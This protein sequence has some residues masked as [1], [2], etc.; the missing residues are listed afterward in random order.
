[1]LNVKYMWPHMYVCMYVCIYVYNVMEYVCIMCTV[2][3]PLRVLIGTPRVYTVP[4]PG[5]VWCILYIGLH[6]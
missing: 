6:I 5:L 1:M 2:F 4:G 3:V